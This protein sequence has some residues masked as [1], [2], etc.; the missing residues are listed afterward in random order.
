MSGY[1]NDSAAIDKIKSLAKE[2]KHTKDIFLMGKSQNLQIMN[3][4]MVKLIEGTYKHAH[5]IPAGDLKHYAITLMEEDVQVIVAISNDLVKS[6]MIN[7]VSQVKARGVKVT[8][9]ASENNGLF[10]VFIQVPETNETDAIMHVV[11][12][13]LLSYYLT[14]ELGNPIDK[15]RNIAKSVTVK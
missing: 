13:Q 14:L 10:D 12:L 7:S 5:S 15:P 6:D 4:G 1:L 2:L 9:I 8:G 3:E 11:P